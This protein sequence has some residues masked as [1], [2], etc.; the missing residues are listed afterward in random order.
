MVRRY[1]YKIVTGQ[2]TIR[3]V[4]KVLKVRDIFIDQVESLFLKK[5]L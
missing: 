2:V 5:N 1:I 4:P 3:E